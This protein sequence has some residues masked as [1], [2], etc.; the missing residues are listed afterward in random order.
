MSASK[1]KISFVVVTTGAPLWSRI[2]VR[3]ITKSQAPSNFQENPTWLK[4][5]AKSERMYIHTLSV[6]ELEVETG[7]DGQEVERLRLKL[8][9]RGNKGSVFNLKFRNGGGKGRVLLFP[10]WLL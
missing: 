6:E 9:G 1:C 8:L 5:R 3:K 10:L 7:E 4:E 2:I